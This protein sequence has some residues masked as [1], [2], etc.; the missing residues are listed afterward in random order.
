MRKGQPLVMCAKGIEQKT[1][2]LM[3]DVVAE[4]LPE[5]T[6][7]VLSGPSFAADVARGLPAALTIACA[8]ESVGRWLAEGLGYKN[9]RLYWS[10]DVTGV[11]LGGSVKNVL[12]IAASSTARGSV[13]A[14]CG[15]GDAGVCG[16]A[17]VRRG[18][19]RA[20]GDADRLVRLG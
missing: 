11:E 20:A 3:G 13:R 7:A 19:R 8:D 12:A 1:G 2:K 10:S 15:S 17:P 14:P 9:F 18:A 6:L 16:I 4:T 5:V